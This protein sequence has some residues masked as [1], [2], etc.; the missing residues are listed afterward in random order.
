[1]QVDSEEEC[2][3]KRGVPGKVEFLGPSEKAKT[4]KVSVEAKTKEGA[5]NQ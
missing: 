5:K 3:A 2:K 1:M 4:S